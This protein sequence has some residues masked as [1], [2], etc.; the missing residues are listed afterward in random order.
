MKNIAII[1]SSGA[2][3]QAFQRAINQQHPDAHIWSFARSAKESAQE[4]FIDIADENSIQNAAQIITDPLDLVFV[5]TGILSEGDIEPEKSLRD[6]SAEKFARLFQINTIGPALVAKYFTPKLNRASRSVFSALSARVGSI[7]DNRLG[8]WYAYRASKAALNMT[9]KNISIEV[10]RRNKAAIIIGLHPGTV[11]SQLSKPFQ[12]NVP[13]EKLFNPDY[14][15]TKLLHVI[16][17][18]Q[19]DDTG[20]VFDFNGVQVPS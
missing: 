5:A 3:G 4:Y 12:G 15:A 10:G 1:G 17:N 9:L 16:E 6:L 18:A 13:E 14:S 2:I 8:G 11:D 20:K 7:E 19:P